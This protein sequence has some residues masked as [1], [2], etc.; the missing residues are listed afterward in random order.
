MC[1]VQA[2]P[3]LWVCKI[4]AAFFGFT[5]VLMDGYLVSRGTEDII[6]CGHT[7]YQTAYN[8][9]IKTYSFAVFLQHEL[10]N[11]GKSNAECESVRT[12]NWWNSSIEIL[13]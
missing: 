3:K 2:C 1:K 9:N 12:W 7:F 5:L 8:G 10:V 13:G 4:C 11:N 6:C